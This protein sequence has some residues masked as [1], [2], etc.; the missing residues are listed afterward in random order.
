MTIISMR[1]DYSHD[2]MLI[3]NKLL[4]AFIF[5][6]LYFYSGKLIDVVRVGLCGWQPDKNHLCP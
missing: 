1:D 4:S 6:N 2:L 3:F 5:I